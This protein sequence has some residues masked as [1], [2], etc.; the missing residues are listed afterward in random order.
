MNINK[1][2]ELNEG[3][4][5]LKNTKLKAAVA[6]KIN[7]IVNALADD[8]SAF[9]KAKNDK[10]MEFGEDV[11]DGNYKVK[12]ENVKEY[13]SEINELLTQEVDIKLESVNLSELGDVE[14][15]P[16]FFSKCSDVVKDDI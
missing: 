1:I 7:R 16:S 5:E 15:S 12:S 6:F 2:I 13:I 9:E 11:G 4:S 8:V 14:L 10:I 3:L